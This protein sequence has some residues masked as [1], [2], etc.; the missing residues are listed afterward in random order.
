MH[1]V[2]V[3]RERNMDTRLGQRVKII[4]GKGASTITSFTGL[5]GM[6]TRSQEGKATT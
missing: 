3:A 6:N 4:K 1:T 2:Q 5:P